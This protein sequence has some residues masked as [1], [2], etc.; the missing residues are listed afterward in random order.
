MAVDEDLGYGL[1]DLRIHDR[2]G[3][4]ADARDVC[5]LLFQ[6]GRERSEQI[7]TTRELAVPDLLDAEV[8]VVAR[9]HL[10]VTID[11]GVPQVVAVRQLIVALYEHAAHEYAALESV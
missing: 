9:E 8:H 5:G 3:V 1:L 4:V 6:H 2:D 7:W 10:A 11:L